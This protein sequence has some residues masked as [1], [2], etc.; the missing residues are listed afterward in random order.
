MLPK[1]LINLVERTSLF[2]KFNYSGFDECL[3]QDKPSLCLEIQ[4]L[5]D[6]EFLRYPVELVFAKLRKR[7]N[8]L[9]LDLKGGKVAHM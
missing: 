2:L 9:N 8:V 3:W 4:F 6:S 1:Y 5:Q 7:W